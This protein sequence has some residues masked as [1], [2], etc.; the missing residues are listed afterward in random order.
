MET[1]QLSPARTSKL[2]VERSM[3]LRQLLQALPAAIVEGP[4]DRE[5]VG[6]THDSRRVG[7]GMLFVAV[8]GRTS[9]GHEFIGPALDRGAAAVVC[10]HSR[11]VPPRAT[12]I[13]VA[14]VREAMACLALAYY[15]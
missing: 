13:R 1:I 14:D 12:R 11:M 3:P 2:G 15:E 4:L 7:P 10:D 9:D 5:I 8:P 6:I